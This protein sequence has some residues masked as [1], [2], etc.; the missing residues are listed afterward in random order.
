MKI[1]DF[2]RSRIIVFLIQILLLSFIIYGLDYIFN[3][4]FDVGIL[5]EREVIIQFLANYVLFDDL[6]GLCFIYICW[7]IVSLVPII[8]YNNFKK[9]YSMNLMTFFFPNFFLYIFLWRYS[10]EYFD[11]NFQ[12]HI[13]HT[14]LLGIVIV[15]FSIGI[16]IILKKIT[17]NKLRTQIEDLST[18]VSETQSTCP[19]CGTKF[20]S[21][22]RFCYK[23]NTD[24]SIKIEEK[25]TNERK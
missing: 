14:I 5:L 10:R 12:F 3:V 8:I 11:S 25:N 6:S 21:I 23:C 20:D 9:A 1:I 24:L 18:L 4:N 22:P 16:S 17:K 2:F 19:K 15:G 7:L 13:L